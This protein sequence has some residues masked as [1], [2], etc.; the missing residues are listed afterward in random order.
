MLEFYPPCSSSTAVRLC[1]R[2]HPHR[3]RRSSR[4][5]KLLAVLSLLIYRWLVISYHESCML[6]LTKGVMQVHS[7]CFL[8]KR[9]SEVEVPHRPNIAICFSVVCAG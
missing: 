8:G 5:G 2:R 1:K 3:G 7:L 6:C 4:Y 9:P